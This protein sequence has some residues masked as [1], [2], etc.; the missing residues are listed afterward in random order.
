LLGEVGGL[1]QSVL[2][3]VPQAHEPVGVDL[4]G[5]QLPVGVQLVGGGCHG[6]G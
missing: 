1:L 4:I 2:Q 6:L 5:R 3:I